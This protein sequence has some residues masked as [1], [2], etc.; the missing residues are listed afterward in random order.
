MIKEIKE[1]K[2]NEIMKVLNEYENCKIKRDINI[3]K[4]DELTIKGNSFIVPY[5]RFNFIQK[6]LTR[7]GEYKKHLKDTE[8][9]KEEAYEID[10]EILTL[11]N[12][13]EILEKQMNDVAFNEHTLRDSAKKISDSKN[14][15]DFGMSFKEAVEFLKE[16]KQDVILR[17]DDKYVFKNNKEY[18]GI[19]DLILVHK[20]NYIPN[21][22]R[23]S[24]PDEL[25]LKLSNK[26][27]LNGKEYEYSFPM[28]RNTV[29]FAV[30]NEVASHAYGDWSDMKYSILI[31][32]I[33][34]PKEKI[35]SLYP[36]DTYT[37]GGVDI[38]DSAYI[39]CPEEEKENVIKNNSN[40]NVIGYEGKSVQD[41][42]PALISG[43]GYNVESLGAHNW[44]D[45]N[46]SQKFFDIANKSGYDSMPHDGSEYQVKEELLRGK[47]KVVEILKIV[48][49][50][51]LIKNKEELKNISEQLDSYDI[52]FSACLS[53]ALGLNLMGIEYLY[54]GLEEAG[55]DLDENFK[56]I[57]DNIKKVMENN[58]IIRNSGQVI[59]ENIDKKNIDPEILEVLNKNDYQ[60]DYKVVCK[61]IEQAS[62]K[63]ILN[64]QEISDREVTTKN[65]KV[66]TEE[67]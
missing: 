17:E 14:V 7:R 60:N 53:Q 22:S 28:E 37:K 65:K 56:S 24:S 1:I 35:T 52:N 61:I 45:K 6:Y 62:L 41:Y 64:Q 32:C 57:I 10:N 12:E 15:S 59:T 38:P 21:Q 49:N 3:K 19:E 4:I 46:S 16:N 23:I 34:I 54:D 44:S 5:K 27:T 63:D 36:V 30:N 51:G 11:R 43:L 67:R 66:E 50:N 48:K 9:V 47:D 58:D 31:P 20:T 55:I 8:T 2:L 26:V 18:K 42:S 39:L 13:N 33:D 40:V 25:G 29:H